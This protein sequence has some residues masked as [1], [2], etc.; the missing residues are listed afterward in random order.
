M[1]GRSLRGTR[2]RR[3]GARCIRENDTDRES[4]SMQTEGSTR[5]SGLRTAGMARDFSD[6]AMD[7]PTRALTSMASLKAVGAINGKT[8]RCTKASGKM[9]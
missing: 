8:E 4:C 9:E 6:L 7:R 2:S 5:D 3:I 1:Q